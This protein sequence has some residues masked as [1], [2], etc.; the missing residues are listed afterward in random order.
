MKY[1]KVLLSVWE[2]ISKTHSVC[3]YNKRIKHLGKKKERKKEAKKERKRG[4]ELFNQFLTLG[5]PAKTV[6]TAGE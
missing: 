2:V 1:E 4:I 6:E 5:T 3:F